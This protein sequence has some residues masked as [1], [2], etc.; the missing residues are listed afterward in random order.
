MKLDWRLI[1]IGVLV[2]AVIFL[3]YRVIFEATRADKCYSNINDSS[4]TLTLPKSEDVPPVPTDTNPSEIPNL[5]SIRISG[6]IWENWDADI[7]KDGPFIEVVYLDSYGE[8]INGEGVPISADVKIFTK[9]MSNYPYKKGRLVF[10]ASYSNN[11]IIPG[12]YPKIRI[13]KEEM[14]INPSVD[15]KYG[16]VSVTIHTP[17]QGDFSTESDFIALYNEE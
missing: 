1:I 11:Q 8:I 10:S 4:G 5:A 14:S 7:E 16:Y 9:D 3:S 6:G 15:Y 13:P 12:L 2:L 17:K